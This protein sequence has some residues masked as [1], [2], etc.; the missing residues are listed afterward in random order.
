MTLPVDRILV[1]ACGELAQYH[2]RLEE[3]KATSLVVRDHRRLRGSCNCGQNARQWVIDASSGC[4]NTQLIGKEWSLLRACPEELAILEAMKSDWGICSLNKVQLLPTWTNPGELWEQPSVVGF[5][6]RD[7]KVEEARILVAGGKVLWSGVLKEDM[8][9]NV[10][11]VK[12]R[13]D[14]LG[15]Q[16]EQRVV[17]GAKSAVVH[18]DG[19]FLV[20]VRMERAH[21]PA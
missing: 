10:D 16:V 8:P 18:R 2:G 20:L 11:I 9:V 12:V 13:A 6:S 5:D 1:E 21:G 17:S 19:G 4:R 14:A 7:K 3:A 15:L